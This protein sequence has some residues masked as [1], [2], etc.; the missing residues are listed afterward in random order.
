MG[1]QSKHGAMRVLSAAAAAGALAAFLAAGGADAATRTKGATF[2]Y[3]G[4]SASVGQWGTAGNWDMVLDP[5]D[6][7][8]T[9]SPIPGSVAGV[10]DI[11]KFPTNAKVEYASQNSLDILTV[12]AG[13]TVELTGAT[14]IKTAKLTVD[15]TLSFGTVLDATQTVFTGDGTLVFLSAPTVA[16]NILDVSASGLRTD[17]APNA[18]PRTLTLKA[19]H[20]KGRVGFLG[21]PQMPSIDAGVVEAG[22]AGLSIFGSADTTVA[23]NLKLPGGVLKIEGPDTFVLMPTFGEFKVAGVVVT[24]ARLALSGIAAEGNVEFSGTGRITQEPNPNGIFEVNTT[25]GAVSFKLPLV[26][27]RGAKVTGP[28]GASFGSSTLGMD[29]LKIES[30]KVTLAKDAKI[31]PAVVELHGGSVLSAPDGFEFA[32]D[33][34]KLYVYGQNNKAS[35]KLAFTGASSVA[36]SVGS[37]LDSDGT[38]SLS[39][40][41]PL[42]DWRGIMTAAIFEFLTKDAGAGPAAADAALM[43]G[44]KAIF[45]QNGSKLAYGLSFKTFGRLDLT[46][47]VDSALSFPDGAKGL[48]IADSAKK[49]ELS[50]KGT[51]RRTGKRT[52]LLHDEATVP[53]ILKL[54]GTTLDKIVPPAGWGTLSTDAASVFTTTPGATTGEL[55]LSGDGL[56]AGT[57]RY[58]WSTTGTKI[59]DISAKGKKFTVNVPEAAKDFLD[60]KL[61]VSSSRR[62]PA[63]GDMSV[64]RVLAMVKSL[65]VSGD[66]LVSFD[67]TV[68][69]K[70]VDPIE[71]VLKRRTDKP[72]KPGRDDP[73][74]TDMTR[75]GIIPIPAS[76]TTNNDLSSSKGWKVLSF[77]TNDDGHGEYLLSMKLVH[78]APL[79]DICVTAQNT[80]GDGRLFAKPYYGSTSAWLKAADASETSAGTTEFRIPATAMNDN[81][82]I[83]GVWYRESGDLE[84]M[85]RR[86]AFTSPVLLNSIADENGN[87]PTPRK[88]ERRR[89]TSSDGCNA[90]FL[91]LALLPLTGLLRKKR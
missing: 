6:A 29:V 22:T 33:A 17:F 56:L 89:T 75:Y 67:A 91:A 20:T 78:A 46:A 25:N 15:G 55:V 9:D 73:R 24:G 12:A 90:G 43:A 86:I 21:S 10:A 37:A 4:A 84:L 13:A 57:Q 50:V 72:F 80:E 19:S 60:G 11:V 59:L 77:K 83:T 74:N 41:N 81:A 34:V 31:A 82:A 64:L 79:T 88:P 23:V 70:T 32:S 18:F 68:D 2:T 3:K 51:P 42:K 1:K 69:D 8:N 58:E 30:S 63:S 35:G 44:E 87:R 49:L 53:D 7:A 5:A 52:V 40:G 36:S 45:T 65:P 66:L 39:G 47:G 14:Q 71:M 27:A 61:T 26:S 16:T 28:N 85:A 76:E 54:S 38:I 62:N 48:A